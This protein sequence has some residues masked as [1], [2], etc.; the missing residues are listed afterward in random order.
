MPIR[1]VT[2]ST[3]DLP[4]HIIDDLQITVV[5]LH[6]YFGDEAFLDGATISKDEFY[7]R[8]AAHR[9]TFPRTAAPSAGEFADVY[10]RIKPD[11]EGIVSIHLSP[12]LSAT[13]SAAVVAAEAL[14]PETRI[15]VVDSTTASLALG[16]LVMHAATLARQGADVDEIVNSVTSMTPHTRFFG[17]L[18]TLE[19]LH[20]GGRI[21]AAAAFLGSML[22]VKPIVGL[23]DG[24]AHPI[25]RV[26]G[27]QQAIERVIERVDSHGELLHL[28]VGHTT[29]EQG[30]EVLATR[31]S[32]GFPRERMVHAQCGATLGTYLGPGAFGVALI[33]TAP[34]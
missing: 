11:T 18:E 31:L 2:D 26:R 10:R 8:L 16:L 23:R 19:Y 12:R 1:I 29:D 6:V 9:A 5:P 33:E 14:A 21:G 25:E 24:V 28:A 7:R 34:C 32:R 22:H 27:R 17:V 13:Y 3:A 4:K 15:S 20:K 30:M